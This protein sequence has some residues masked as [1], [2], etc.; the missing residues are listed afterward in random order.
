MSISWKQNSPVQT[1]NNIASG[2]ITQDP[3]PKDAWMC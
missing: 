2:E 1:E 3:K